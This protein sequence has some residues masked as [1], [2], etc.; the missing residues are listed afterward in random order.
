MVAVAATTP[1]SHLTLS[2]RGT[3][4]PGHPPASTIRAYTDA[5]LLLMAQLV[6]LS[7]HWPRACTSCA[8]HDHGAEQALVRVRRRVGV[9]G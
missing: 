3:T 6:Q 7:L 1:S 8:T 9:P 5:T 2:Q 4:A